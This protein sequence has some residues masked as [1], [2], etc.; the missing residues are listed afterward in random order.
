MRSSDWA[1]LSGALLV[2]TAAFGGCRVKHEDKQGAGGA[3]VVVASSA[4]STVTVTAF[5][6]SGTGMMN[7]KLGA[8]CAGDNDCD[9]GGR[10]VTAKDDDPVF[11]GGAVG[12]YCTK[13]CLVD[14]DCG[15]LAGGSACIFPM[16][17]NKGECLLGCTIGPNL[18]YVDD[19]LSMAKCHGRED[20][21]CYPIQAG[22]TACVPVCGKDTQC[23]GR[24][25]DPLT[26]ACVTTPHAGKPNGALCNDA[27]KTNECAGICQKFTNSIPSIC[28]TPCVLGGD[29][30]GTNDCGGI[31]AGLCDYRPSGYGPGDYGRCAL[32]CAKHDV[33]GNPSW[34]CQTHATAKRP[35]CF[36]TANCMTTADCVSAKYT[37]PYDCV[38][39]K[40]GGKCL[41]RD[42]TCV[43]AC[44]M[45]AV[46]IAKCPPQFPLGSAA[47]MGTGGA[48]GGM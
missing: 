21:M 4:S 5:A 35:Y 47:P 27:A 40:Y 33:C 11:G 25:C 23:P 41:E 37:P 48:G 20:A 22:V 12:G 32:G 18:Q 34:W 17:A 24:K 29:L 2:I 42:A 10:C 28:V 45:D 6:S 3:G 36:T 30:T 43:K 7:G 9:P 46:C 8:Q 15:K 14:D 26:G 19:P 31:D 13:D 1:V 38:K 16:G 44:S 39:T